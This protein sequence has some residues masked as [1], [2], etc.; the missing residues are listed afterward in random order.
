[1]AQ[2]RPRL[3]PPPLRPLPLGSSRSRPL[4][5]GSSRSIWRR[6]VAATILAVLVVVSCSDD[7]AETSAVT[8]GGATT[9]TAE[10]TSSD[11]GA[12]TTGGATTSSTSAAATSTTST[13][14]SATTLAGTPY[15]GFARKGDTLIVVGVAHDDVLNLRAGPGTDHAVLTGLAPV[16][17]VTATGEARQ[18][19]RTIWYELSAGQHTGWANSS[20]LAFPGAVDDVTSEVVASMGRIPS[21]ETM[22]DLGTMVAQNR[23][24]TDVE[25]WIVL[26]V[27]PS[28]GALGEVTYDVIGLAD[29]ALY[30]VRLRVFGEP[31]EGGSGFSLKSVEQT[32]L[33][34]RGV[35]GGGR[36]A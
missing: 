20:Y 22:I 29:D 34:G 31:G 6:I 25:S 13:T 9:T 24:S 1:M 35:D 8:D 10:S 36:C 18:L 2:T 11:S 7:D 4:P 33:C 14:T 30:G 17:Q 16:G 21:A 28:V 19:E 32:T 3:R 23:A 26:S 12:S 15:E 5:L 27:G